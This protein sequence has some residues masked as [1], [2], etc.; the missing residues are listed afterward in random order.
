MR[1]ILKACWLPLCTQGVHADGRSELPC[2]SRMHRRAFYCGHMLLMRDGCQFRAFQITWRNVCAAQCRE[3]GES[4]WNRGH[5]P[6]AI[7]LFHQFSTSSQLADFL[8]IAAYDAVVER[9]SVKP[10][11]L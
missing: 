7:K 8:T 5:F 11:K 9:D 2:Q 10:S 3:L 1:N 4:R 6:E